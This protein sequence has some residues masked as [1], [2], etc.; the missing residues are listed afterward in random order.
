MMSVLPVSVENNVATINGHYRIS[1]DV[2]VFK[3]ERI[4]F[5]DAN[6]ERDWKTD[7]C[8]RLMLECEGEKEISIKVEK[9]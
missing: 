2:G 1:S 3:C 9:I 5:E 7:A 4:P 6:L 8:Y